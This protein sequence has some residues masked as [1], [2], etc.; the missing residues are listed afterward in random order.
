[1]VNKPNA[2][3]ATTVAKVLALSLFLGG[4]GVGYVYQMGQIDGLIK[5]RDANALKI[6]DLS[7]HSDYLN[8][9]LAGVTSRAQLELRGR[10]FQLD[11]RMPEPDQVITLPEPRLEG[12][13]GIRLANQP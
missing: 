12:A 2:V 5:Q 7:R 11:L 8:V 1:M 4:S 3:N 10:H 9:R 13:A 6:Y